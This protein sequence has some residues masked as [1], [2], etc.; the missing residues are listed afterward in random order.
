MANLNKAK[1]ELIK[2]L[3]DLQKKY[4]SLKVAFDKDAIIQFQA[5][6]KLVIA[7]KELAFQNK[8]KEKRVQELVIAN[9]EL[10][11]L[12]SQIEKRSKVK[13]QENEDRF[14]AYVEQAADA[15]FVHDFSG[16]FIDVNQRACETLGYSKEELLNMS[17]FDVEEDFD[18][19][20]AQE[21]W[22]QIELGQHFMFLGHQRRKDGSIFPVEVSFGCFNMNNKRYFLGQAR[23]ITERK[24]SELLRNSEKYLLEIITQNTP[25][26]KILEEIVLTVEALSEKTIASILLLDDDGIHVHY[27]AAP[28]LPEAYNNALEGAPIGP[29]AG[30]CGTAAYRKEAIIVTDIEVDPLWADYRELARAFNLRACWSTPIINSAGKVLGTF[31]MYYREPRSPKEEDFKLIERAT[32]HAKIAMERNQKEQEL[33]KSRKLLLESQRTGK[34]GGWEINIDTL[35][36][37]WTEEVFRIHEVEYNY[38]PTVEMGV[39]YYAPE[40][41]P[42]IEKAIQRAIEYGEP[43]DLELEII[44][45]RGNLRS[46]K[47]IGE[48]DLEHHRV[49]GFFQDITERKQAEEKLK[50]YYALMH[51]AGETAK[52]GGWSVN[53]KENV[54]LWSNEVAE[55]HEMPAGYSPLTEEGISFYAPEWRD[56]ITQVFTNCAQKGIRYDEE[57]E[58]LTS[59]GNRVWVRTIGEAVKNDKGKIVK[60]HGA[61]QDIS[62]RKLAEEK[63]KESEEN[64]RN[65]IMASSDSIYRMSPDWDIM[66]ELDG[67]GFIVNTSKP[68]ASWFQ[69]YIPPDDQV[70]VMTAMQEAIRTKSLF[71]LEH[72]V[73]RVDGS[74]GWTFSRAIPRLDENGEIYEWFGAAKDITD[75]KQAEEA[76]KESEELLRLSSELASVAAWEMNL[77][78]DSMSRSSN[79]DHLYGLTD[80]DQWHVNTFMDATHIDDRE[81]C[82]TLIN[83]SLASGGPDTYKFDF[84]IHYPDQS[85]HWLNVIGSVIERDAN[86]VG[87]K[88]RG[89][90]TDI[91]DRK[92]A[93]EEI[94]NLN[95][96]LEQRVIERTAQLDAVN[97]ELQTFTYSVSHD[98]RAP[99]RGIDG[100][101]NLL[102]ELY[103]ASL[104]EEAQNFIQ[105][106]RN[107]TKQMNTL[108]N[109][110]LDYSRL[111]RATL[112]KEPIKINELLKL[113]KSQFETEISNTKCAFSIKVP[114]IEI[115]ADVQG[116]T[117]ALRNLIENAIKFSAEQKKPAVEI[118]LKIKPNNWLLAVKDNGIG[119]DM[120]YKDRIFEIF[121]QLNLPEDFPGTGIGL[122]MVHKSMEKMGGKVWAKSKLGEGAVFYL[123]IPKQLK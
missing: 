30:S 119:F 111:E 55:I 117:I 120:K 24:R 7:N 12:N 3:K 109:D 20:K 38:E 28:H 58:I 34:V 5:K 47:A 72:R 65:L 95:E 66:Y 11:L 123:E 91:T 73:W 33:E 14:R 46:V 114:D 67:R 70:Y 115:A 18:L 99:L 60:V 48:A 50:E 74:F 26:P 75:R 112:R 16:K 13:L 2:E 93:E 59:K 97:K 57:M 52:L 80:V 121:Q 122:A 36:Q 108:I 53:L 27:G 101:S 90:I 77:V 21:G 10:A 54:V 102:Q 68:N 83:Q 45:A 9:K 56:K 35:K 100:Y 92:R 29:K 86:G 8:E 96:T 105:S 110:L 44:T 22:S 69:E 82:N 88:I 49:F 31:A 1:E 23:D 25:F 85:I 19:E 6:Q 78:A 63:L 39:N 107:G 37:T 113:L 40:S 103:S 15:L 32:H 62:V 42:I 116:L 61:F 41:K 64:F 71:E 43:F 94:K 104:N 89:F 87:I 118:T 76:L 106:I 4:H 84:R 17:V 98:L 79:H 81:K 51:I